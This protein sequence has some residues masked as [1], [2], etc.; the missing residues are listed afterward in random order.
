MPLVQKSGSPPDEEGSDTMRTEMAQQMS[1]QHFVHKFKRALFQMNVHDESGCVAKVHTDQTQ[2]AHDEERPLLEEARKMFSSVDI[3]GSGALDDE[4]VRQ[5]VKRLGF[6]LT[7]KEHAEA[8]S[9][10]DSDGGGEVDFEEFYAWWI[11]LRKRFDYTLHAEAVK[12]FKEVDTDGGGTLS[13]DEVVVLGEKLGLYFHGTELDEAMAAMDEDG[14]GEVDFHE[15]YEW[16]VA[17]KQSPDYEIRAEAVRVFKQVDTDGSGT[18]AVKE[19][20]EMGKLMDFHFTK[21]EL[22]RAMGEM[23]EDGSGEVDFQE[24]YEWWAAR[25]QRG[26]QELHNEA[27]RMFEEV[28]TDGGG[29]L[30][31][32]EVQHLG[33]KLGFHFSEVELAQAMG[34]MDEDGSGEVDFQEFYEWYVLRKQ[35]GTLVQ[36]GS[37]KFQVSVKA[38]V[39]ATTRRLDEARDSDDPSE[40]QAALSAAKSVFLLAPAPPDALAIIDEMDAKLQ[41]AHSAPPHMHSRRQ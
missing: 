32:E 6:E 19:V 8:M 13:R 4:E 10:M 38:Q 40:M 34:E 31:Q 35:R 22:S 3:D 41:R 2:I 16:W 5:L 14:S 28:D 20:A 15:F 1:P 17:R 25:K 18:L 12:L 26:D 11:V 21:S 39:I 23:D 29:T 9:A 33:E 7:D 24:F 27:A 36:V 37:L 30:S